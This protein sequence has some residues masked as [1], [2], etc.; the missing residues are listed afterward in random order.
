[1]KSEPCVLQPCFASHPRHCAAAIRGRCAT[2]ATAKCSGDHGLMHEPAG[3]CCGEHRIVT[4]QQARSGMFEPQPQRVLL[5]CRAESA[6]EFAVHVKRGSSSLSGQL[7]QRG[8]AMQRVA[9]VAQHLQQPGV[10]HC[11]RRIA[12]TRTG[13]LMFLALGRQLCATF[14]Q[15]VTSVAAGHRSGAGAFQAATA[16]QGPERE[17]GENRCDK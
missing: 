13:R 3:Q 10:C 17:P 7:A 12:P 6:L 14:A 9:N 4:L 8:V 1:M 5:G 2:E 16:R 11:G 15:S